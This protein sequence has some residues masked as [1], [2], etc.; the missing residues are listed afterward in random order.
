MITSR[1]AGTAGGQ[2]LPFAKEAGE[3]RCLLD[4]KQEFFS[5]FLLLIQ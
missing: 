2:E 5:D 1:N 3:G 4:F